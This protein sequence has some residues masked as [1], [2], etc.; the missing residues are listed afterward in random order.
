MRDDAHLLLLHSLLEFESLLVHPPLLSRL[1]AS[2]VELRRH[3][4][5]ESLQLR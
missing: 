1:L 4:V 2:C 3:F 5:H